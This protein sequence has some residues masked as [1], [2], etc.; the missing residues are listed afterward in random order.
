MNMH[1]VTFKVVQQK[2]YVCGNKIYKDFR[3][4]YWQGDTFWTDREFHTKAA[5]ERHKAYKDDYF[6]RHKGA[7]LFCPR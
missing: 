7:Y 3:V 6:A 5:A 4:Q 2:D 1:G